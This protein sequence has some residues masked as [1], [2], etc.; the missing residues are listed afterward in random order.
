[1]I[2]AS[3][4]R[5]VREKKTFK[6]DKYCDSYSGSASKNNDSY[7]YIYI[8][9]RVLLKYD[10]PER[11]D[12]DSLLGLIGF[13]DPLTVFKDKLLCTPLAKISPAGP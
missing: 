10:F 7:I 12:F 5:R 13:L 11:S 8:Y 4:T 6:T 2:F 1:M 9:I 3:Q